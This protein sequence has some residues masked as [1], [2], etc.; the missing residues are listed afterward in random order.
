MKIIPVNYFLS[1]RWAITRV[2]FSTIHFGELDVLHINSDFSL[3]DMINC[4]LDFKFSIPSLIYLQ[5]LDVNY[6]KTLIFHFDKIELV[7]CRILIAYF[8]SHFYF[9]I[10]IQIYLFILKIQWLNHKTLI[11][12]ILLFL[13]FDCKFDWSRHL[14]IGYG[15]VFHIKIII[16]IILEN[17]E[18][19]WL[20]RVHFRHGPY[21]FSQNFG[22][23]N[24][25]Y[26]SSQ[27]QK[28]GILYKF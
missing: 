5:I 20:D 15:F 23:L 17:F 18:K 10:E 4:N 13:T 3:L 21:L 24:W 28:I 7:K 8:R 1:P 9:N 16:Y 14:Q 6:I 19:S 2:Q 25:L 26:F 11:F 22:R 12:K 27:I